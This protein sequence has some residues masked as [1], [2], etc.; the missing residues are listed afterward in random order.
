M[1]RG[2]READGRGLEERKAPK[3]SEVS[4][5]TSGRRGE[6]SMGPSVT[7]RRRLN[8]KQ[9]GKSD[10]AVGRDDDVAVSRESNPSETTGVRRARDGLKDHPSR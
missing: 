7:R 2:G 6:K 8:G 4:S 1:R 9:P 3:N 5:S 10:A